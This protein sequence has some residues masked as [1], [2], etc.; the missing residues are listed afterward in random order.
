MTNNLPPTHPPDLLAPLSNVALA[1]IVSYLRRHHQT[2]DADD[3]LRYLDAR[4][5]ARQRSVPGQGEQ[6]QLFLINEKNAL[7]DTNNG[8][9]S[10]CL[11]VGE[12]FSTSGWPVVVKAKFSMSNA[13][14]MQHLLYLVSALVG[15]RQT[16]DQPA[17]PFTTIGDL[18]AALARHIRAHSG[19][20]DHKTAVEIAAGGEG[21]ISSA[22]FNDVVPL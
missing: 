15:L 5:R 18:L 7:T 9:D 22:F 6:V 13:D 4:H 3:L 19:N 21:A 11:S 8:L 10:R 12:D 2:T 1:E 16:F 17:V 14:L 20:N